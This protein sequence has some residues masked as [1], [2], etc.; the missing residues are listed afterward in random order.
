MTPTVLSLLTTELNDWL[1][2]R[3]VTLNI[4]L[5]PRAHE[6]I[7]VTKS[8]DGENPQPEADQGSSDNSRE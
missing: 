6:T 7:P 5:V 4:T 2:E 3:G 8:Q 1:T